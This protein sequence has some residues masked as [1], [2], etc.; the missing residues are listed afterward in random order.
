MSGRGAGVPGHAP[1]DADGG[2]HRFIVQLDAVTARREAA[3][4]DGGHF[5]CQVGDGNGQQAHDQRVHRRGDAHPVG[6][7]LAQDCFSAINWCGR[8]LIV[9]FAAGGIPEI[10]S[11]RLL[12]KGAAA[13]GVFWGG[14]IVREPAVNADNFA[15]LF[16]WI[17]EGRLKPYIS[18]TYPLADAAEAMRDMQARKVT[19]KIVLIP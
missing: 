11:N 5:G 6:G 19:G 13:L 4:G 14:F 2:E 10:A 15:Q 3:V 1:G 18:K 8:Y 17:A 16:A 9:G 7:D 12:L